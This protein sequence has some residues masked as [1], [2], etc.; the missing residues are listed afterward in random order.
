MA[1]FLFRRVLTF[2]GPFAR[3]LFYRK[4]FA[5]LTRQMPK[6][7][8]NQ[9]FLM[10]TRLTRDAVLYFYY[11]ASASAL[12]SSMTFCW[13][14]P[15]ASSYRTNLQVKEPAPWVMERRSIV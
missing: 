1:H 15:G 4:Q 13:T 5:T 2:L 12:A 8:L 6:S 11:S 3:I 7:F 10:S 9:N 14:L